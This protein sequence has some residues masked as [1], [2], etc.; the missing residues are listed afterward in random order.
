LNEAVR[1]REALPDEIRWISGQYASIDFKLSD[2]GNEFIV[3]A[4][5]GGERAGIGRLQRIDEHAAELGGIYV[6]DA[7][8]GRGV[9]NA[10]VAA[11]LETA[12]TYRQIFCLPFQ[13]LASFY[14]GFGFEPPDETVTV[15]SEVSEKHAWCNRQYDDATLLLVVAKVP[16][17]SRE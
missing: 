12:G 11:L 6:L 13:H 17:S 5:A 3:I 16:E 4:E 14:A 2:Y 8:R 15:P 10:I 7:F 1:V 9:A